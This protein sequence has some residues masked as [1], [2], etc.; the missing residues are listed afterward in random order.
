LSSARVQSSRAFALARDGGIPVLPFARSAFLEGFCRASYGPDECQKLTPAIIAEFR[1]ADECL[2]ESAKANGCIRR[3][4][5]LGPWMV[6]G[7]GG[8]NPGR[9]RCSLQK[10]PLSQSCPNAALLKGSRPPSGGGKTRAAASKEHQNHFGQL[11]VPPPPPPNL[12]TDS[13]SRSGGPWPGSGG[14]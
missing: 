7:P 1:K 10:S 14:I 5:V 6:Q 8:G 9:A 13:R 4:T 12:T 3:S 2:P 11:I